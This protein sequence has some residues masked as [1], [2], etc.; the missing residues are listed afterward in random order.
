MGPAQSKEY[1]LPSGRNYSMSYVKH[2]DIKF[3]I[4]KLNEAQ[5]FNLQ[6][7]NL[8]N[9]NLS[10]LIQFDN[11]IIQYPKERGILKLIYSAMWYK[12][13]N[14][15]YTIKENIPN[16]LLNL[17]EPLNEC[18]DKIINHGFLIEKDQDYNHQD[19]NHQDYLSD[20][21]IIKQCYQSNLDNIKYLLYTGNILVAGILIDQ[22]F[23]NQV[24]NSDDIINVVLS[25]IIIIIGYNLDS[26]IIKTNW[27]DTPIN[28][29]F[30]FIEN[31]KEIWN[32]EIKSPE[33]NYLNE[34]ILF[35]N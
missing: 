29:S 31:I 34:N 28:L 9:F 24:L 18:L 30:L 16:L 25:D 17:R 15:G 4:K 35:E 8:Q 1:Y 6:N 20:L 12:I 14:L 23:I 27:A 10:N 33:E 21:I 22:E 26:L 13:T 19:Y 5:N 2:T 32:F 7:F 3:K 11:V